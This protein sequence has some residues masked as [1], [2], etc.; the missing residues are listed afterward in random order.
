MKT[1]FIA[2]IFSLTALMAT[3]AQ[4][5]T[6]R[7][8]KMD[9]TVIEDINIEGIVQQWKLRKICLDGQAY[10]LVMNGNTPVGISLSFKEK[11]PEQCRITPAK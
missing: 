7:T 4:A 10:L 6:E 2:S 3:S 9:D 5:A 1:L 8:V 11:K